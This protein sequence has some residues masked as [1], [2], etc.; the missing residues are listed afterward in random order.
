MPNKCHSRDFS[1]L[2]GSGLLKEGFKLMIEQIL[3]LGGTKFHFSNIFCLDNG[4]TNVG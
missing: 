1:E 4:K 2:L 3:S